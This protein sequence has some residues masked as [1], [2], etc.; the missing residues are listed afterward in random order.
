MQYQRAITALTTLTATIALAVTLSG[1]TVSASSS[2]SRTVTPDAFERVVVDALADVSDATPEVDCGPDD[3]AIEDGAEVHCDVNTAG[4]DV[5]YDSVSTIS[6][7]GGEE[8]H[9][10][11]RVADQPKG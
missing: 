5:V 4:Y 8:Y 9:V 6:T 3:I 10:D 2:M 7:D 1:C 11:V